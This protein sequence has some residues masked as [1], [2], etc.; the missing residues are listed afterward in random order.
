MLIVIIFLSLALSIGY[1]FFVKY[2][3]DSLINYNRMNR[4]S[5]NTTV[6]VG[7]KVVSTKPT[8]PLIKE[9]IRTEKELL[10]EKLRKSKDLYVKYG[11]PV[12]PS[13]IKSLYDQDNE[14]YNEILKFLDINCEPDDRTYGY[15]ILSEMIKNS[16]DDKKVAL[17]FHVHE[18]RRKSPPLT[19]ENRIRIQ[20]LNA[21]IS[22]S[23][24][25]IMQDIPFYLENPQYADYIYGDYN[26]TEDFIRRVSVGGNSKNLQWRFWF[27]S[28][29]NA[30]LIEMFESGEYLYADQIRNRIDDD[31]ND[32]NKTSLIENLFTTANI[33]GMRT[34][35][36]GIN[37][38]GN[39]YRIFNKFLNEN[40]CT[41]RDKASNIGLLFTCDFD[42]CI[43]NNY[44][45]WYFQ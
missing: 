2:I 18:L 34:V 32:D 9:I 10:E 26:Q 17:A 30:F 5:Y 29:E 40:I 44:C 13:T 8:T 20:Q 45:N 6:S 28:S 4:M 36:W 35:W 43:G 22:D 7:F 37:P 24:L 39:Y 14:N 1:I 41:K 25:Y 21:N 33:D 42:E 27:N 15:E 12:L 3:V 11:S 38:F 31:N 16:T 23:I 19:E